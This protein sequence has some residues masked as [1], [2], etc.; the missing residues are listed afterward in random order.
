MIVSDQQK[1]EC[2]SLRSGNCTDELSANSTTN[3]FPRTC[4]G[5]HKKHDRRE[6]GLFEEDLRC[7]ER[8][9]LCSKTSC[10]Y[11]SQS[12]KLKVNSKSLNKRAPEHSG[13]GPMSKYCKILEEVSNVTSTYRGFRTIQQAVAIYNQ[14]KKGL[15]YFSPNRNVQQY[16]I[17]THPLNYISIESLM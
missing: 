2:N 14:T 6:H 11:D 13:D 7:T 4:C 17:H 8:I 5:K 10:C 3:F 12:H 15:S 1:K 9:F 16:G